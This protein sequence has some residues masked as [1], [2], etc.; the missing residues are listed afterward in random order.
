MKNLVSPPSGDDVETVDD[1]WMMIVHL[2]VRSLLKGM[3][4]KNK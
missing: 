2:L 4:R 1:D 3:L